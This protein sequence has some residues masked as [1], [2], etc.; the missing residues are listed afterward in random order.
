MEDWGEDDTVANSDHGYPQVTIVQRE[1]ERI[2]GILS[3]Q[4][5]RVDTHGATVL[6]Q[7]HSPQQGN[8]QTPYFQPELQTVRRNLDNKAFSCSVQRYTRWQRDYVVALQ[9]GGG[10]LQVTNVRDNPRVTGNNNP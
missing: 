10:H 4:A 3:M 8:G 5:N 2:S 9:G 7:C 6:V 1:I